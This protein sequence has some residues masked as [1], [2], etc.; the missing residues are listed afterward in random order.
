MVNVEP[1]K[2]LQI[3]KD[4]SYVYYVRAAKTGTYTIKASLVHKETGKKL[5]EWILEKRIIESSHLVQNTNEDIAEIAFFYKFCSQSY[6]VQCFKRIMG[7]T[8]GDYRKRFTK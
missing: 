4:S 6:Y 1:V 3:T 5:S 7:V 2:N 8:P